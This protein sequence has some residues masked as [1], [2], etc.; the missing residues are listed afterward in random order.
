M[1]NKHLNQLQDWLKI[2][3]ISAD[4]VHKQDIQK[5]AEWIRDKLTGLGV[6]AQI[7][8]TSG[9]PVVY[10]ELKLISDKLQESSHKVPTILI[11]GHYDVQSPDPLDQWQSDPFEPTIRDGNLYARGAADDKGQFYTWIAAVEELIKAGELGVNLKFLIEGAEEES[12]VGLP[13]YIADNKD[14]LQADICALSDTHCLSPQQ[15]L[16]TYGLRGLCYFEIHV[17]TLAQDAHSGI[18][19]GNVLNAAQV[20]AQILAKL[21]DKDQRISVPHFYDQVRVLDSNEKKELANFPWTAKEIKAEV[22]AEAVV[23]EPDTS[24]AER[25]GAR[26]ALD[27]NGI[28]SGYQGEGGKTIIPAT[29]GAKVSIRLVPH[30]DPDEIAK[31]FTKYVQGLTPKGAQVEVKLLHANK[32]VLLERGSKY[33]QAAETAYEKVFGAKPLYELSGGSIGVVVDF[34]EILGI[35]SVM[36]GYG[37]PDDNLHGPNEKLSIEMFEKGIETN[38]EFLKLL[39]S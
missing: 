35:D 6:Q 25:A 34:K 21:K 13:E 10:G 1:K 32:P 18:Y 36:M 28:W 38:K 23:G 29:A 37:L 14:R 11:Y 30:Q 19:G 3:S 16:I 2:P 20:L 12:S 4:P 5:A 9:H 22:G 33:F 8:S 26:P 15:P 31:L 7:E 27:I 24:L 39:S 17:Q